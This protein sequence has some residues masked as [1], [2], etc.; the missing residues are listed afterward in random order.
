MTSSLDITRIGFLDLF[1][2]MLL[3]WQFLPTDK[4]QKF[5]TLTGQRLT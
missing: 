1:S 2:F 5:A 4:V 3:Y